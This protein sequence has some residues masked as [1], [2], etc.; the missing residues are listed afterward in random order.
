MPEDAPVN[1]GAM[2][3]SPLRAQQRVLEIQT[4]LHH[5][6]VADPGR[7]FGD[8]FNLVVDPAF[9][10]VAWERVRENKGA[11]SAGVDGRTVHGI[12]RS[13]HGAAGL[14][15]ELRRCESPYVPA[16]SGQGA[17]DPQGERE[18]PSPG[19]PHGP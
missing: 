8:L 11:R 3:L 4:K 5:W 10:A 9:L 19:H 1:I 2:L 15:E 18:A 17:V 7:R 12:E 16:A 14:L 6:A 13:A